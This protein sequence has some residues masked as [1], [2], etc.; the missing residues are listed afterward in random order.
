MESQRARH[1]HFQRVLRW[2]VHVC[3][4]YS[5]W[6]PF[7]KPDPSHPISRSPCKPLLFQKR[8]VLMVR[9]PSAPR[10]SFY[11]MK[12]RWFW[13]SQD[14][15]AWSRDWVKRTGK[16]SL[17]C[18]SRSPFPSTE[19]WGHQGTSPL[20][21]YPRALLFYSISSFSPSSGPP[22]F[23]YQTPTQMCFSKVLGY[24]CIL[25]RGSLNVIFS[26]PN[27]LVLQTLLCFSTWCYVFKIPPCC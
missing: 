24:K 4:F 17:H 14:V 13:T 25:E 8:G 10:S 12:P 11:G 27:N 21:A 9:F 5:F 23:P 7:G 3:A 6:G 26:H 22:P 18:S 15:C 16:N 2:C 20:P 19:G 1:F